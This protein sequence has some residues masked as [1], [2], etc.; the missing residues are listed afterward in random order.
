MVYKSHYAVVNFYCAAA[1]SCCKV[2]VYYF[3]SELVTYSIPIV[4]LN[5]KA[6]LSVLHAS[7]NFLLS[8]YILTAAVYYVPLQ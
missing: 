2:K 8:Q 7:M 1:E 3:F 5:Y 6:F 4:I